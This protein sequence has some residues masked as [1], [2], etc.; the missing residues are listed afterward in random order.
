[1]AA[2]MMA[3]PALRAPCRQQQRLVRRRVQ[4][5]RAATTDDKIKIGINGV[6]KRQDLGTCTICDA[7]GLRR[8]FRAYR[9]AGAQVHS[10]QA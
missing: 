9:Q 7:S 4:V 8:R 3:K 10:E 6:C 1:M 5:V 2:T